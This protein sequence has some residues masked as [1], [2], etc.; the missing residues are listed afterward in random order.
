M[1]PFSPFPHISFF[2][3]SVSLCLSIVPLAPT[4]DFQVTRQAGFV[5]ATLCYLRASDLDTRTKR[6]IGV[7]HVSTLGQLGSAL[8]QL[9]KMTLAALIQLL[10]KII[11]GELYQ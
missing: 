10:S 6:P 2:S 5:G 11:M 9:G 7:I 3:F 4:P 8:G 1:L